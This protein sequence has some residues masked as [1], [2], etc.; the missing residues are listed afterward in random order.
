KWSLDLGGKS[1][2]VKQGESLKAVLQA[3]IESGWHLYATDQPEGGPIP[4]TIKATE[5][6]PFKIDGVISSPQPK[7]KPDP[8]FQVDGQPLETKFFEQSA[9]FTIPVTATQDTKSEELS[10]DVR[11]QLCN[12]TFCLPPKTWRISFAGAEEVK[13]SSSVTPQVSI[14]PQA[15]PQAQSQ[16]TNDPVRSADIW[17]FVWLAGTLGALSLL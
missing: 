6:K 13:K 15:A 5:G 7:V 16:S 14:S 10:F 9:K 12:D 2:P 1:G 11:F 4:T 8:N 3:E 17:A